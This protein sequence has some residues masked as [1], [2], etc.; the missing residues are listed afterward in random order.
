[1]RYRLSTIATSSAKVYRFYSIG[2]TLR[3][4]NSAPPPC[5]LPPLISL[6]PLPHSNIACSGSGIWR[7][8]AFGTHHI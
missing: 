6:L 3:R 7:D 8:G 4:H 5:H 2:K 1:M